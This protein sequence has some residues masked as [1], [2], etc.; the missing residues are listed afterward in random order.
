MRAC[1]CVC[2]SC[3]I[4]CW[5]C[6]I[7]ICFNI[8]FIWPNDRCNFVHDTKYT[9]AHHLT[10]LDR[11]TVDVIGKN[12]ILYTETKTNREWM[13]FGFMYDLWLCSNALHKWTLFT[14]FSIFKTEKSESPQL[15]TLITGQI[16]YRVDC[17]SLYCKT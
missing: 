6:A 17:C 11:R 14:H 8:Y 13:G 5:N 16:V 12:W 4:S 3:W 9:N 1:V 2:V 15:Y 7:V 10:Y